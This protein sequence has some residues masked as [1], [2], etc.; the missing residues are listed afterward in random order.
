MKRFC[1]CMFIFLIISV[2]AYA[3][4]MKSTMNAVME[5]WI[6]ENI[7][8]VISVWGYPTSEQD[9]AGHKLYIWSEGQSISEN[10][11]GTALINQDVC[12]RTFEVSNSGIIT[13]YNWKGTE[14]P[15]FRFTGKKWI[16]PHA[17]Y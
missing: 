15:V 8:S 17:S 7:D 11:W 13:N 16:N 3:V 4:G 10:I 14:C 9:I 2:P 5:G 1:L 12:T 6:G